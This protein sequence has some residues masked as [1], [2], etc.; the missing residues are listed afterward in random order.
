MKFSFFSGYD[1]QC[2]LEVNDFTFF[3]TRE[4]VA[5]DKA[6]DVCAKKGAEISYISQNIYTKIREFALKNPTCFEK[7][8]VLSKQNKLTNLEEFQ[9]T[10]IMKES[11]KFSKKLNVKKQYQV[12]CNKKL[13]S[14]TTIPKETLLTTHFYSSFESTTSINNSNHNNKNS[15]AWVG[16][17]TM[18]LVIFVLL[19][20]S[21][22]H[23]VTKFQV[24]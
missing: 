1:L 15:L 24:S 5:L 21:I 14:T 7:P 16:W 6:F 9:K 8:Y 13:V 4:R 22:R 11:I 19:G 23:I 17:T 12:I 10:Y 3:V 20:I 18:S 2:S